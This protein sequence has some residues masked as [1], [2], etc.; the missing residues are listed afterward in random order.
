ML[1][2]SNESVISMRSEKDE[3]R[4]EFLLRERIKELNCLYSTAKLIEQHEDSIEMIIQ[5]V[6]EI[7]PESWQYPDI[8][9][10]R[11]LFKNQS[12][13]S[14]NFKPARWKQEAAICISAQQVGTVEVYYLEKK[15][16]LDEGPFLTEERLLINAVSSRIAKVAKRISVQRQLQVEQQA[17]QDANVAIHEALAHSQREKKMIG[18]SI[19]S[20]IDKIITPILFALQA[21]MDSRQL[22]YVDLLKKNLAD[23]VSPFVENDQEILYKLSPVELLICNMIKHGLSTKEIASTRRISPST[24]NR[25]RESIRRK[26]GL[27][28]SKVNL[29]SYLNNISET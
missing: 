26:L 2:L 14:R 27:T 22:K 15:P 1:Y 23:I 17:L 20:N 4:L 3:A 9:C 16:T 5:G 12:Y 13:Q 8:T 18:V 29:I 25:H 6:V 19:Q 10:A 21:E 28:N 11:I 7:L 24:V